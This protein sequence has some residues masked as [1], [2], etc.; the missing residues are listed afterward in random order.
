MTDAWFREVRG[1]LHKPPSSVRETVGQQELCAAGEFGRIA[2]QRIAHLNGRSEL[3][4][5]ML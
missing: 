1:D 4:D 3:L 5:A 2:R